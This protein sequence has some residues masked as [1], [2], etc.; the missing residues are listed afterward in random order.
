M[1]TEGSLRREQLQF[2]PV[3]AGLEF[4]LLIAAYK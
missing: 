2:A 4:S 3:C 1:R